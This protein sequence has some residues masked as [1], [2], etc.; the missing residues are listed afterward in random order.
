MMI[1]T[2]SSK[3]FCVFERLLFPKS[4]MNYRK[5][6][7]QYSKGNQPTTDAKYSNYSCL[8][9]ILLFICISMH[10]TVLRTQKQQFLSILFNSSLIHCFVTAYQY[11]TKK[12]IRKT[13]VSHR[14]IENFLAPYCDHN[15]DKLLTIK[16]TFS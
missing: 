14:V 4:V 3:P 7:L 11:L 16:K 10:F 6:L 8:S 1:Y 2:C 5:L 12:Y 9:R 13:N 15:P